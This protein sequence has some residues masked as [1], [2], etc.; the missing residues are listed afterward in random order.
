MFELSA[1]SL[2]HVVELCTERLKDLGHLRLFFLR[3]ELILLKRCLE[4]LDG[5]LQVKLCG[6][7]LMLGL[8]F[9]IHHLLRFS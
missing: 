3:R 9:F 6:T 5:L 7:G 4:F 8:V 2:H 1:T